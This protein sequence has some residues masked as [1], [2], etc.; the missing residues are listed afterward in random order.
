MSTPVLVLPVLL[1]AAAPQGAPAAICSAQ[2]E[3]LL[4]ADPGGPDEQLGYAVALDGEVA[5]VAAPDAV[6][7]LGVGS[8]LVYRRVAGVWT[9]EAVLVGSGA[10]VLA[11]GR[12]V[13]LSEDTA[14]VGTFNDAAVGLL[15]GSAFVFVETGTGWIEQA[16]LLPASL[17]PLDFFGASVGVD[18]DTV[19]VGALSDDGA[20]VNSGTAFAF[21]RSGGSWAEQERFFPA[22]GGGGDAFG[23]SIALVG[24]VAVVGA[25]SHSDP[26]SGQGAAYVFTRTGV[27]WTQTAKLLPTDPSAQAGFGTQVSYDGTHI[28][29]ATASGAEAVYV[30]ELTGGGW[31]EMVKLTSSDPFD[32]FGRSVQVDDGR[33]VVGAPEDDDGGT[34]AGAAHVYRFDGAAWTQE[35]K[36][37][38]DD[39]AA[40]DDLG[41]SVALDGDTL[42]TGAPGDDQGAS[43]SG[44]AYVWRLARA[45]AFYCS[46]KTTSGGCLPAVAWSGT[47]SVGGGSFDLIGAH[48]EPGNV[49]I[50][51]Y[52]KSGAT[53]LPFLGG[54]LCVQPPVQRTPSSVSTGAPPCAGLYTF[55]FAAWTASGADP[56]LGPGTKVHGQFWF[57]DPGDALGVGLTNAVTFTLCP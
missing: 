17:E 2:E 3:R 33:L 49:G 11:F 10:Q 15:S 26:I 36:L 13:D 50:F 38:A 37:V 9:Q 45:P 52:G 14:V 55:D 43:N 35:F 7:P 4:P 23:T 28:A 51:F 21:V 44:S 34:N 32:D 39:A 16:K 8:A 48:V 57:R 12:S 40:A 20:A 46:S 30:F 18:G 29:V 22:D 19:V 42:L 41:F 25:P 27:A 5:L 47:P 1:A 24:D 53:A 31:S 56:V 6:P 54:T